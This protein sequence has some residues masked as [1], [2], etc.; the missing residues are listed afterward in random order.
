MNPDSLSRK[1]LI[2]HPANGGKIGIAVLID[3][4]DHEAHFIAMA[5][6]HDGSF[7]LPPSLDIAEGISQDIG[8]YFIHVA[9]DIFPKYLLGGLFEA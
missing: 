6:E 8:F 9:S 1:E 3:I 2:V 4:L 7:I 5:G